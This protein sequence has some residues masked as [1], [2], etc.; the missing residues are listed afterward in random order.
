MVAFT[1]A[2]LFFQFCVSCNAAEE[3]VEVEAEA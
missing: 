3:E 2:V 1:L